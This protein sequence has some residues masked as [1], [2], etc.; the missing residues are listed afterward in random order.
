MLIVPLLGCY[1]SPI[2]VTASWYSHRGK[3]LGEPT[4]MDGEMEMVE[5]S[6]TASLDLTCIL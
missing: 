3:E 6:R 4:S 5:E 2:P 1:N